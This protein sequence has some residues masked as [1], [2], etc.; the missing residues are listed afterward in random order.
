MA[1]TATS[2]AGAIFFFLNATPL[3]GWLMLLVPIVN[4][5]GVLL[6]LWVVRA[7]E[8]DPEN[9]GSIFRFLLHRTRDRRI[10]QHCNYIVV[11]NF[12]TVFV[13][14][15]VIGAQ[16]F[17]YFFAGMES[18]Q[19][20]ARLIGAA[21]LSG[22]VLWY[23]WKGGFAAVSQTDNWQFNLVIGGFVLTLGVL[24]YR[25]IDGG[26]QMHALVD[27]FAQP[28]IEASFQRSFLINLLIINLFL[29]VTQIST[30]QRFSAGK[31]KDVVKGFLDGL[32]KNLLPLWYV[33]IA[34]AA[35]LYL[36]TGE[37]GFEALFNSLR[38]GHALSALLVFPLLFVA[39]AAALLSTADSML[40]AIM[41][42]VEDARHGAE[43][44]D[45]V[46]ELHANGNGGAPDDTASGDPTDD[47]TQ[48]DLVGNV[49]DTAAHSMPSSRNVIVT[50]IS[51]VVVALVAAFVVSISSADFEQTVTQLL[52]AGYGMP[53]LLFPIVVSRWGKSGR[54]RR[55]AVVIVGLWGGMVVLWAGSIYGLASGD[56]RG[57]HLG[58]VVG[59]AV[60]AGAM[61]LARSR[62]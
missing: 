57:T 25:W 23:V 21:L 11:L 19:E 9:T 15:I 5:A 30:W 46:D 44:E 32:W 42:A 4:V 8:P 55:S 10:A 35:I 34:L 59:I 27:V 16:I 41:L 40:I 62:Q 47:D 26:A 39:L 43:A 18:V 3:F 60:V 29:P 6:F 49:A 38:D 48:Q 13:I 54:Q 53:C 36:T 31:R 7:E 14:E 37:S 24:A 20:A 28:K 17:S 56:F 52:F 50:G 45:G 22:V 61:W 33:V 51:V 58:P 12:V 1:A 2:L